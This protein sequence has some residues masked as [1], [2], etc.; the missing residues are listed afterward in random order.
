MPTPRGE[1]IV[2]KNENGMFVGE[3]ERA[4]LNG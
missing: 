3:V 2:W 4:L 1:M